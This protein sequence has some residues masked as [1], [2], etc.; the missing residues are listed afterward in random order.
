MRRARGAEGLQ[1][2]TAGGGDHGH[3][4][5]RGALVSWSSCLS[6]H[7]GG[8]DWVC[9]SAPSPCGGP[10]L[11]STPWLTLTPGTALSAVCLCV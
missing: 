10:G 5:G 2:W 4:A 3:K 8:P 6:P 11:E 7:P 1:R 9:I